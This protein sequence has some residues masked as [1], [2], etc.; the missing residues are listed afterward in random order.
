ILIPAIN[1][2][3]EFDGAYWHRDKIHSDIEK[4]QRLARAGWQI[5]RVREEPLE[6]IGPHDIKLP[7]ETCAKRC[8]DQVLLKIEEV[9][10]IKLQSLATYLR[11]KTPANEK[12]ALAYIDKR[13][14]D[15][16]RGRRAA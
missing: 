1:L 14:K 11:R 2:V 16:A 9:C 4:T 5:I 15:K 10:E 13:L 12:A 7:Q 3:I 8:A 6:L